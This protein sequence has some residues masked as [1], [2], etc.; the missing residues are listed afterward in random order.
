MIFIDNHNKKN[1]F[2]TLDYYVLFFNKK[3]SPIE[4]LHSIFDCEFF[5]PAPIKL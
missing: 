1:E 4:K 3:A 5:R 2:F